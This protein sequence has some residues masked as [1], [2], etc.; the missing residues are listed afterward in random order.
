MSQKFID[1]AVQMESLEDQIGKLREELNQEM[2]SVG[3]G[4]YIQDPV[5]RLVYKIVEPKG[6]FVYYKKIDYVR[7]AKEL[8]RSGTLSAKD[9]EKAGFKL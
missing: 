3:I 1:L 5:T 4:Q 9:A 8:E 2:L 6:T 7:T